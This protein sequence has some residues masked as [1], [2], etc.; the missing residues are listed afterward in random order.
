MM[1]G[2]AKHMWHPQT[3]MR[4]SYLNVC[5]AGA[6]SQRDVWKFTSTYKCDGR[7]TKPHDTLFLSHIFKTYRFSLLSNPT[8]LLLPKIPNLG[9]GTIKI[10]IVILTLGKNA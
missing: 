6:E 10:M 3:A 1:L 2:T 8:L 9:S 5:G 7:N 4:E